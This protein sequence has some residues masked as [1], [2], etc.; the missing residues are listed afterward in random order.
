MAQEIGTAC[1][2]EGCEKPKRK[3]GWCNSHY[4]QWYSKGVVTPITRPWG[5]PGP[6]IVCGSPTGVERGRRKYCSARCTQYA[7]RHGARPIGKVDCQACGCEIDLASPTRAGQFRR[8][9]TKLCDRCRVDRRKHPMSVRELA[10]RDGTLCGICS[11]AVDMA[12]TAPDPFRPSVDHKTPR[13]RGGA[14]SPENLQ[15]AHLWCNQVKSDR[16]GFSIDIAPSAMPSVGR[17]GGQKR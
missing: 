4:S 12:A 7:Q 17:E 11:E 16:E 13:A 1:S 2:V 8:I 5:K 14:H 6:C 9:D 15:L 10:E 3:R